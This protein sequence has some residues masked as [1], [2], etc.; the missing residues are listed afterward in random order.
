MNNVA[1]FMWSLLLTRG[2]LPTPGHILGMVITM[3][4][5][6]HFVLGV[7]YDNSKTRLLHVIMCMYYHQMPSG[8]IL[9]G[10]TEKSVAKMTLRRN[11]VL[12]MLS[13]A[14]G[15]FSPRRNSSD[16]SMLTTKSRIFA[17]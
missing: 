10:N 8:E 6:H 13:E 11:F 12:S 3:A 5:C 7:D 1:I 2:K 17:N 9:R 15:S 14:I 16:R 4:V